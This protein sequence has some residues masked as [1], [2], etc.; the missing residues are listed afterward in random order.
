MHT[1]TTTTCRMVD[2]L[3]AERWRAV[4]SAP[5]CPAACASL[6]EA[7]LL[8]LDAPCLLDLWTMLVTRAADTGRRRHAKYRTTMISTMAVA[9]HEL[10]AMSSGAALLS[11]PIVAAFARLTP[12][13]TAEARG[14]L[15]KW[16]AAGH[17]TA[18]PAEEGDDE[19]TEGGEDAV[20][21]HPLWIATPP[22]LQWPAPRPHASSSSSSS[23][24]SSPRLPPMDITL[25]PP[26]ANVVHGAL[27]QWPPQWLRMLVVVA[28]ECTLDM[29]D[30]AWVQ[31]VCP[32]ACCPLACCP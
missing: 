15:L 2:A 5:S 20:A 23:S 28:A 32:L 4:R 16:Y 14:R 31:C 22:E 7:E 8:E 13:M 29:C 25:T 12:G 3:V 1:T 17:A 18:L 21:Q 9:I 27:T 11:E 19:A 26:S 10:R 6:S 30:A 24:S